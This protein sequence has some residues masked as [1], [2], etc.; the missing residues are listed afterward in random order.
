MEPL[1]TVD[2]ADTFFA[3]RLHTDVWDAATSDNKR[4]AV[5]H[6]S[7]DIRK[8]F[9]LHDEAFREEVIDD[10]SRIVADNGVQNAVCLQAIYLLGVN[11]AEY[12]EALTKGV[13]AASAGPLNAT[14]D[15]SFIPLPIALG[16]EEAIGELGT[17]IGPSESGTARTMPLYV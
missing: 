17:Y 2:Y 12:P 15:K 8:Y 4:K 6:A 10:E 3:N 13:S 14:F 9:V 5:N 16:V 7:S 11:P 1:T